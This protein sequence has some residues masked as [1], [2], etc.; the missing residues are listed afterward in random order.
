MAVTYK[1]LGQAAPSATTNADLYVV[2]SGKETIVSTLTVANRSTSVASSYRIAISPN[3]ATL[4]D[5]HYIAFGVSLNPSDTATITLG[6]T[7]DASDKIIVYASS[8]NLTFN[9]FG[10]ELA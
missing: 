1:I 6:I 8:E 10:M 2:P 5:S 9:L 7:L 3:G 4:E